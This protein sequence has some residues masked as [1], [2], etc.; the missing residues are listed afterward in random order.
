MK[1]NKDE[2]ELG[3]T[4]LLNGV[5]VK[6]ISIWQFGPKVLAV[7]SNGKIVSPEELEDE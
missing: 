7:L 3:H 2:L 4:Y 6:L 5:E 1:M